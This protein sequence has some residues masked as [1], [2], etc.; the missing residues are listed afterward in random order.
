MTPPNQIVFFIDV[1]NTLLDKDRIQSDLKRHL[2]R[3]FGAACRDRYWAIL[4][5]LFTCAGH[6]RLLGGGSPLPS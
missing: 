3:E 4:E 1:D 5:Q 2:E 6:V